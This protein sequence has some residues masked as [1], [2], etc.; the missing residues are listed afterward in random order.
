M[1]R[2]RKREALFI[3]NKLAEVDTLIMGAFVTKEMDAI[4]HHVA[5]YPTRKALWEYL[6]YNGLQRVLQFFVGV[7]PTVQR[8]QHRC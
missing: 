3:S 4:K 1:K 6:K 2:L 7:L 8:I 5:C